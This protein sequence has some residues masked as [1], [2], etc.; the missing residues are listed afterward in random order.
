MSVAEGA[1]ERLGSIVPVWFPPEMPQQRML[2]FLRGTLVDVELFVAPERLVLVVDGCP[3]AEKPT[4][5]V[6]RELA[7]RAGGPAQV[8]VR[9]VNGGK[10]EAVCTGLERL[11]EDRAVEVISIRDADGDH[12]VYDLPQLFRLFERV[13]RHL[14]EEGH[15]R[16]DDLFV[17]GCRPSLTR[18]LGLAR[19][20]LEPVLNR[21]TFDAVS[22]RLSARGEAVDQ[23][24]T[25]RYGPA[26]DFQ[27]GYK[28]YS[29]SAARAVIEALR[30]AHDARPELEVMRWGVEFVPTVELLLRGFVPAAL[31]RLTWNGQPQTTFDDSDLP[32]AYARQ[33]AWLFERLELPAGIG[34][35]LLDNALGACEY[36][37]APRGPE[38]LAAIRQQVIERCYADWQASPPGR[39]E[40]FL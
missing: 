7:E 11:L 21:L 31:Q 3:E 19:G 5:Q 36:V 26:P 33:I 38:H 17:M 30:G 32:H 18:S 29:R 24:F 15:S 14:A 10:G 25:A 28:L 8:L 2:A 13:R 34:M 23:R 37:T 4:H 16:P 22:L 9:E 40:L 35:R 6:A 20:E 1:R 39:G 27:S 12:D